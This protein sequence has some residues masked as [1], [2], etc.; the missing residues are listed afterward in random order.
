MALSLLNRGCSHLRPPL[1]RTYTN[2]LSRCLSTAP[3]NND[4]EPKSKSILSQIVNPQTQGYFVVAG[5]TLGT[6]LVGKAIIGFTSFF[7]HL[8]PTVVA[9]YGFCKFIPLTYPNM[10]HSC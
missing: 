3:P 8:A 6:L 7:T 2:T 5:G 4:K 1:S 9:K 10:Y